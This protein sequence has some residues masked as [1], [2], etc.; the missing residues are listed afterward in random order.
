MRSRRKLH[1]SESLGVI[2]RCFKMKKKPYQ[3]NML[4]IGVMSTIGLPDSI[5]STLESEYGP[6]LIITKPFRFS[7]TDYYNSEMGENIERFFLCFSHLVYPDQLAK[8]KTMTNELEMVFADQGKRKINLDPGLIS[9]NNLVLATTKNRSHRIAIGM[10]LYAEV[11]LVYQNHKWQSFPW[12]YADYC[13]QTVQE[14]M[15]S[16]R[17]KYLEIRRKSIF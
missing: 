13:S 3:P 9:E 5:K 15:L 2:N 8:I 11:T 10:G 17:S 12:T 1:H 4:F 16:F 6:I 14:E 7:F